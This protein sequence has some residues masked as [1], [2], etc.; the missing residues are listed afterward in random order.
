MHDLPLWRLR[1]KYRKTCWNGTCKFTLI[2][3]F[4]LVLDLEYTHTY[5]LRPSCVLEQ[6][7]N[8]QQHAWLLPGY[9]D[10]CAEVNFS[11]NFPYDNTTLPA[12]KALEMRRAYWAA[13]YVIALW[14][15]KRFQCHL[16]T[17]LYTWGCICYTTLW[18]GFNVIFFYAD[19]AVDLELHMV[20]YAGG[21]LYGSISWL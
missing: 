20:H 3:D 7:L 14:P 16:L 18:R 5:K 15:V 10:L 9:R 4:L 1:N 6:A 2:T 21:D 19:H 11:S 13:T 8:S 17:M 12:F